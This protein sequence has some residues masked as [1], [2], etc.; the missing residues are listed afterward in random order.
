MVNLN[1]LQKEIKKSA[2]KKRS[3]ALQ[4]Y[5]KT[6]EGEYGFGDIFLGLSVPQCRTLAIKYKELTFLEITSLLKSKNHEERLIALLLLV[7]KFNKEP[8]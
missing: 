3:I 6:G 8:M 4:K 1:S 7:H 2:N 5:F